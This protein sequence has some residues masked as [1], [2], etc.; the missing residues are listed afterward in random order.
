[1]RWQLCRVK[2][3]PRLNPPTKNHTALHRGQRSN[4]KL[5]RMSLSTVA[6]ALAVLTCCCT[7]GHLGAVAASDTVSARRPLRGDDTVVSAKVK[8][9]LGLFSPGSS[10]RFYLGI[11]YKNVPGKTVIWVGNRENPLSS[12][13][14]A[15]LRV[16]TNDGNL[17]LVGLGQSSASPG[18]VWS[19]SLPPNST[20]SKSNNV[21]VLRDNGN[22]VL[23]DGGNSSSSNSNVLWQS[24]DHP[25]DTLVPEAWIGENKVTGEY[26]TLRSWRNAED[27]APGMFTDTADPNGSSEFFYLWNGSRAYWRS[28]V[29][30]GRAFAN[31]PQAAVQNVIFNQTYADTPAYRRVTDVLY[32]NATVTRLVLDLT[33]QTKQYL[34]VPC[35]GRW[36]L[37]WSAPTVPCDAYA[38]C[39]A[40]GICNQR[41]QRVRARG[42]AGLGT[43]RL[44]R[45]VPPEIAA[46]VRRQRVK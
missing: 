16:S 5:P 21:A 12:V 22:L 26:Q 24:F 34:W 42:G 18:V 35:R 33:G 27:P 14:S 10:G 45:R 17:E 25:T 1:M 7:A 4:P 39:G 20:G 8:F 23:L 32:D 3:P 11:W 41:S 46:A 38:L 2:P 28:G 31:V 9:E 44:E 40:F 30:T 37:T 6:T 13:S 43:R 19:S 36:E 15:E 29:W